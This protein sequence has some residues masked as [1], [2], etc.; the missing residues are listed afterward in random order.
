MTL[1]RMTG[2]RMTGIAM[3]E[4]AALHHLLAWTSPSFPTGAFSYSQ[5][6]EQ[7]VEA[8]SVVNDE[9]LFDFI[10]ATLR[11]GGIWIDAV[12]FVAA[13]RGENAEDVAELAAAWRGSAEAA[14]ESR[15]QGSAF[16]KTVRAASPHPRI[17]RFAAR[18]AGRPVTHSVAVA[19]ACAA[20][21]V[22]LD[23]ALHGWLHG[24]SANLVSAGIRLGVTGQTGGQKLVARLAP[25]I[26]SVAAAALEAD[27]D[28]LGSA[29]MALDLCA[30]LHET[31]HMR[32]F[33][34]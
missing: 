31:Q 34:S 6:L 14:L 30:I 19:V 4:P 1:I 20:H 26:A 21:S 9:T 13:W 23:Y 12:L 28:R 22:P 17:E 5:G 15:Q 10:E 27:P 24:A 11:R 32:L 8:G 7:A 16:L 29:A 18:I 2:I 3:I 33:R 25:V